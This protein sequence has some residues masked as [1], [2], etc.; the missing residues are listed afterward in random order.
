VEPMGAGL[1]RVR[2]TGREPKY[3]GKTG[4]QAII[5]RRM[6]KPT[7]ARFDS[8]DHFA[9]AKDIDTATHPSG[10]S[11]ARETRPKED[12]VTDVYKV[13]GRGQG[14]ACVGSHK[15]CVWVGVCEW[16]G[17]FSS[18]TTPHWA[19][20]AFSLPLTRTANRTASS[21][22]SERV[23]HPEKVWCMHRARAGEP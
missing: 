22:Q 18:F 11:T 14:H 19:S 21:P 4:Q 7:R 20:H 17:S 5:E 10:A 23:N 8:G 9:L 13:R 1:G 3:H 15:L 12:W 6:A 16:W 2:K